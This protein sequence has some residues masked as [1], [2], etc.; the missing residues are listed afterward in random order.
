MRNKAMLNQLWYG[1][2]LP[3]ERRSTESFTV[4]GARLTMALQ[5]QESTLRAFFDITKGLARGTGFL[6]RFLVSW[7]RSTQGTQNFT[8]AWV[9]WQ[10]CLLKWRP[11]MPIAVPAWSHYVTKRVRVQESGSLTDFTA[12]ITSKAQRA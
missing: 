2:S 6:A 4:R 10:G 1:V 12:V 11:P 7:P 8:D 9:V 5:V 3:V